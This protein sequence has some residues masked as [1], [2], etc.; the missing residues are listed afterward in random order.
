[1]KKIVIGAA[2]CLAT[3]M[4][5]AAPHSSHHEEHNILSTEL[6]AALQSDIKTTYTGYWITDLKQE[7]ESKHV[8]YSLTLENAD[9]VVHLRAGKG[10]SWEVVDTIAKAM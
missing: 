5:Q 1:M 6:P 4:S 9:Q 3:V 7:G 10:D 2:L 8:K